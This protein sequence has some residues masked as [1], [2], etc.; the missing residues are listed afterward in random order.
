MKASCEN[1]KCVHEK[2][3]EIVSSLEILDEYSRVSDIL[4][5]KYPRVDIAP[6]INLIIKDSLIF[7]P[8]KVE[9]TCF[10]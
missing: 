9:N 6:F 1:I 2:R 10:S 7:I 5:K 3:I 4:S 8:I